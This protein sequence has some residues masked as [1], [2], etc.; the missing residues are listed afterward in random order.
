[1]QQINAG[2]AT[3]ASGGGQRLGDARGQRGRITYPGY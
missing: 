3:P 2:M 1:M